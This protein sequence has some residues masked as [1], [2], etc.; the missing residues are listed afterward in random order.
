MTLDLEELATAA[1]V[2]PPLEMPAERVGA[3]VDVGRKGRGSVRG[4]RPRPAG[5]AA[6][7]ELD[8][9]AGTAP[10]TGNS[11]HPRSR[12]QC[13]Q[14]NGPQPRSSTVRPAAKRPRS[15]WAATGWGAP[16]AIRCAVVKPPAGIALKPP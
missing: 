10:G 3:P 11:Q 9:I 15:R 6:V 14:G 8:L 7:V 12:L 5:I 4:R 2:Q 1:D 16:C 13:S